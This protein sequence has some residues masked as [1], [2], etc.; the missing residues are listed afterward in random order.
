MK[1]ELTPEHRTGI[2]EAIKQLRDVSGLGL[3]DAKD[4]VDGLERD[5]REKD[6]TRFRQQASKG[7]CSAG[8]FMAALG[9]GCTGLLLFG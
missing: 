9:L 5:L 3:K 6:P 2:S 7:G 1:P 8:V 4:I